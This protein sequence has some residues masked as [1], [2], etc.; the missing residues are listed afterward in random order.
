MQ[1]SEEKLYLPLRWRKPRRY[2]IRRPSRRQWTQ[3]SACASSAIVI[4]KLRAAP[5]AAPAVNPQLPPPATPVL[6]GGVREGLSCRLLSPRTTRL[7]SDDIATLSSPASELLIEN[8]IE[9]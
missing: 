1:R 5:G 4:V 2:R 9:C 6:P 7:S 3:P 8:L